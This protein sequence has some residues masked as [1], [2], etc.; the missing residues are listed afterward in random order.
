M[1]NPAGRQLKTI[2]VPPEIAQ[3]MKRFPKENWSAVACEAFKERLIRLIAT[4]PLNKTK[5]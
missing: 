1:N 3:A 4:Q 5:P 2:S